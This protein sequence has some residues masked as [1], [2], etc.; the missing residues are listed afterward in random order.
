M[1]SVLYYTILYYTTHITHTM[2]RWLL[3]YITHQNFCTWL[4]TSRN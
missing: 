4:Q 2:Y 3:F 1:P